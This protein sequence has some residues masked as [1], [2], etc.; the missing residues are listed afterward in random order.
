[1]GLLLDA[2]RQLVN[3]ISESYLGHNTDLFSVAGG[4][5]VKK[6]QPLSVVALVSAFVAWVVLGF[7]FLL[8][9]LFINHRVVSLGRSIRPS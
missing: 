7:F 4:W 3:A 5:E 2:S 1:L 8:V 9:L 6:I